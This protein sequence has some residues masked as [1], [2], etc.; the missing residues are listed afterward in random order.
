MLGVVF[1]ER[2]QIGVH[3]LHVLPGRRHQHA[4]GTEQTH[5]ATEQDLQHVVHGRR[6]GAGT[7]H[8]R[9]QLS[10][11]GQIRVRELRRARYGPVAV[12]ADGVDFTV[13][14]EVAERLCQRPARQR[15]GGEALVEHADMRFQTL[16][17]EIFVEHRQVGRHHQTLIGNDLCGQCGDIKQRVGLQ[18][19]LGTTARHKQL[20]VSHDLIERTG[21][22]QNLLEHRQRTQR[23]LAENAVVSR[24]GTPAGQCQAFGLDFLFQDGAGV[25]GQGRVGIE[26]HQANRKGIGQGDTQLFLRDG[27]EEGAR[28][29]QQ[30]AAAVASLA[31][32]GDGTAMGHAAE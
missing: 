30:Q 26:K 12:T 9:R 5:A 25:G 10:E 29:G 7:V 11:T 18:L 32:S 4:Q 19:L 2:A 16:V 17:A 31:I 24:H 15:I 20:A 3:R 22:D 6:V 23:D 21:I 13:V 8:Q 27:A 1:V 28:H 14:R